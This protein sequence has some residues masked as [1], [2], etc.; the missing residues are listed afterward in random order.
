M[1][2]H[3]RGSP[4]EP[5]KVL[6][7]DDDVDLL[8]RLI[9]GLAQAGYEVDAASDGRRGCE[10]VAAGAPDV[11]VLDIIMPTQDGIES[12]LAIRAARP[13]ARIVAMSGG[14]RIGPFFLLDLARHLGADAT[15]AKPFRQAALIDLIEGRDAADATHGAGH[16]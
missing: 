13:D 6:V 14:G 11:V 12:I 8:R 4:M 16:G 3:V 10:R 5:K 15:I 7:I 1:V 9:E 2:G